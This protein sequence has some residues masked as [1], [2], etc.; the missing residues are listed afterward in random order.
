MVRTPALAAL[1]AA[2]LAVPAAAGAVRIAVTDEAGKPVADA[3][4]ELIAPS[5]AAMPQSQVPGEAE[6]DQRSRTFLPLVSLIRKGGHAVFLNNDTTMHQ[7]YSF[8]DIKQFQF[9][10]DQGERSRP[11][12]FDRAGVAAIGC[13]I[14]DQMI[15]YVYVAASPFAAAS[16]ASGEVRFADVPQGTY[17]VALWHP[18]LPPGEGEQPRTIA[19]ASAPAFA[20]YALPLTAPAGMSHMHMGDY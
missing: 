7:V 12:E 10:I 19:V 9:E 5:G 6:I 8:S 11:V 16:D 18:R 14:H 2:C 20:R 3:V 17:K 1:M 13:N 15:A 4:V